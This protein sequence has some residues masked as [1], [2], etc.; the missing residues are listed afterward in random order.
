MRMIR[1]TLVVVLCLLAGSLAQSVTQSIPGNVKMRQVAIIELPG[2]PGYDAAA[3]ANGMLL[4]AHSAANTVDIFDPVKRRLVA[5]VQGIGE[6][7]GIVV[8]PQSGLAYIAARSTNSITVLNTKDWSV[9][10]VIGLKHAPENIALVPTAKSLLVSNPMSASVSVVSLESLGKKDAELA[11]IDLGGRPQQI[12]WDATRRVAY[13]AVEDRS[14][15][16]VVDPANASAPVAK[17]FKVEASQP[18]GLAFD[19]SARKL[20]VAVRYAVLQMDPDAGVEVA[21]APAAAGTDTLWFDDASK[22]L[23]AAAGDGSVHIFRVSGNIA[24]ENEF[25]AEVRGHALAYD[26]TTKMMYLS[27]GRE[28]KSKVLILKEATTAPTG[29][30]QTAENR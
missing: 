21:R 10:G 12:A 27:G 23:Y 9:A 6:P 13:V 29:E 17:R 22:R 20:F 1:T 26:P 4:M 7:R 28:G 2:R 24:T 3:F 18:T 30:A 16:A 5:Q 25:R 15:I 19:P 14:E 8:D 11:T